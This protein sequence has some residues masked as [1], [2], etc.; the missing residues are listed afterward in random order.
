MTVSQIS[1]KYWQQTVSAPF[2][3]GGVALLKRTLP[4]LLR[5][6]KNA[7]LCKLVYIAKTVEQIFLYQNSFSFQL[8]CFYHLC[9]RVF[10]RFLE[11]GNK[12]NSE[13]QRCLL[14][15]SDYTESVNYTTGIFHTV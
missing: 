4:E 5:N 9:E 2:K 15:S 7:P 12:S 8:L 6:C 3:L 11:E 1:V 10:Q 13:K 14:N